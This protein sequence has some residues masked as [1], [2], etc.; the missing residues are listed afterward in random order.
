[1]EENTDSSISDL[2]DAIKELLPEGS[3][4][5]SQIEPNSSPTTT[6]EEDLSPIDQ[7]ELKTESIENTLENINETIEQDILPKS[8]ET[9]NENQISDKKQ[10]NTKLDP[11]TQTIQDIK[12]YQDEVTET[13]EKELIEEIDSRQQ[14]QQAI[15]SII[16]DK[17]TE[18]IEKI[19]AEQEIQN[20]IGDIKTEKLIEPPITNLPSEFKSNI[21]DEIYQDMEREV[22][23]D[24]KQN[25]KT[26]EENN[27]SETSVP[28]EQK[29]DIFQANINITPK[30]EQIYKTTLEP[31]S[32]INNIVNSIQPNNPSMENF[33]S[34]DKANTEQSNNNFISASTS[35]DS[36]ILDREN[37]QTFLTTPKAETS[38]TTTFSKFFTPDTD[39][40]DEQLVNLFKTLQP[41]DEQ[42]TYESTSDLPS[43]DLFTQT[44][45]QKDEN[46][47][48]I[49]AN[50]EKTNTTLQTLTQLLAT[51]I[52]TGALQTQGNNNQPIPVPI[53][54]SSGNND[55]GITDAMAT[56]GQGMISGIRGKFIYSA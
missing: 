13:K 14:T 8:I 11:V 54:T 46:S 15:D 25:Q 32:E 48:K 16:E 29:E 56:A 23:E 2:F 24:Y 52:Q 10:N 28:Q 31:K 22:I 30:T 9:S 51:I 43:S 45:E 18:L 39:N 17:E 20:I 34:T 3:D 49:L 41:Q 21:P 12:Q 1:M 5:L 40:F 26:L 4:T 33:H 38:E 55:P 27:E 7:L 47:N 6:Q 44:E 37:Y 19:K 50:T 36:S 35:K 42:I 53:P